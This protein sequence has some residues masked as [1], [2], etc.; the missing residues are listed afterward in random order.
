MSNLELAREIFD[1]EQ[2]SFALVKEGRLLARGYRDGVGELLAAVEA[3]GTET[4]GAALADKIV[5]KAVAMIA[6]YAQVR[7]V[8]TPLASEAAAAALEQYQI[9]FT[10]DRI[11]PLI[12]NRRN[13][14]PCPME[15]LTLPILDPG[16]AV[17]TLKNFVMAVCP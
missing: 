6:A 7:A 14:G 15:K 10:A 11:V 9:E 4:E 3:L 17:S 5:G 8:Y 1:S 13:D 16:E 2:L 12:R